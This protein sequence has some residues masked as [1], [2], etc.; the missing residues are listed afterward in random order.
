LTIVNHFKIITMKKIAL[1]FGLSVLST[2][3]VFSQDTPTKKTTT[4]TTT[5]TVEEPT[6]APP[7]AVV[8]EE[9]VPPPPAAVAVEREDE[10]ERDLKHGYIGG[11]VLATAS[12]FRVVNPE[13]A[14]ISATTDVTFGG[15]GL[16]GV[17]FGRNVGMQ[18]EVLYSPLSQK[19][20]DQGISR[21]VHITYVNIPLLLM[22]NTDVTKPVNF[23]ICGGPQ[24]G[25]NT[26]SRVETTHVEGTDQTQ[27]DAVLKVKASD[28]GVA[29]GAGFDFNIANA[30]TLNIGY[31]GVYGLLDISDKSGTTTTNQ[32]YIL[33]R[34]Q[35]QTHSAY[36]G[37][38]ILF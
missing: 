33:N 5:T 35:V 12:Y 30:I 11:R 32:Y 31:R 24:L 8:V 26:G 21:T 3:Y 22:L 15:G 10:H 2:A 23:N 27:V 4:T 13:G 17:N 6:T 1:I 37:L 20:S 36:A 14:D 9:P 29:F 16:L 28:I 7:P 25:I 19:Y 34:S 18:L 38:N